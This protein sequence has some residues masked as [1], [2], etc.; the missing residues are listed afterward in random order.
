MLGRGGARLR[1]RRADGQISPNL[2]ISDITVIVWNKL[3]MAGDC[4]C[5]S[6]ANATNRLSLFF[7]PQRESWLISE[8]SV[9]SAKEKL[10]EGWEIWGA[11]D[12][13]GILD[14]NTGSKRLP[15]DVTLGQEPVGREGAGHADIWGRGSNRGRT[16]TEALDEGVRVLLKHRYRGQEWKT[17]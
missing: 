5:Q 10:K 9:T 12:A 14:L 3:A 4:F 2:V 13:T 15:E 7:F 11:G 16:R 1:P 17:R 8:L 6:N